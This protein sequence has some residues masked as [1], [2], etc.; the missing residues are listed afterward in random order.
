MHNNFF[1]HKNY[2]FNFII[3]IKYLIGIIIVAMISYRKNYCIGL[4]YLF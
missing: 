1:T 2:A 3:E 4:N